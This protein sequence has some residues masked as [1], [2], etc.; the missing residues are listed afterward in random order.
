MSEYFSSAGDPLC[1]R[2]FHA[3]QT[4]EQDAR[5]E[6]SLRDEIRSELRDGVD[7][8]SALFATRAAAAKPPAAPGTAFRCGL[9]FMGA[10]L[11][12]A[13]VQFLIFR[14]IPKIGLLLAGLGFAAAARGW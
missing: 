8:V 7:N 5:A 6:E 11:A 2:C 12:F 10:G 9:L 3:G 1:R 14:D 4:Q 13:V